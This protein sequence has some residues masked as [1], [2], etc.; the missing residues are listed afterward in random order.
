MSALD[1]RV[2]KTAEAEKLY[3]VITDGLDEYSSQFDVATP[4]AVHLYCYQDNRLIGA[5]VAKIVLPYLY[6]KWL[7]VER[8]YRGQSIGKK[9]MQQIEK[10]ALE[11][12][13]SRAF[14]D[15]M[16]YQAPGFYTGMGYCEAARIGEFYPK[17]DRVFYQKDL[18]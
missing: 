17:H 3:H 16:S 15:T 13:C 4:E 9:L 12:Q 5:V 7:W 1:Y 10:M 2:V 6:I 18:A 14:V 8:D 11:K